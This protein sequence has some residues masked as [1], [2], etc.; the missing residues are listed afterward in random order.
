MCRLVEKKFYWMTVESL[1]NEQK[2][3]GR[4]NLGYL[5]GNVACA[6]I[7]PFAPE[8]KSANINAGRWLAGFLG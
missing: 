4:R 8:S 3:K 6:A 2:H 5:D 7:V 1:P